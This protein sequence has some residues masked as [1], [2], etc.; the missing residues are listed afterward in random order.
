MVYVNAE[1]NLGSAEVILEPLKNTFY[2][3]NF[4]N[5]PYFCNFQAILTSALMN[6]AVK[7]V[8]I[9]FTDYEYG[10]KWMFEVP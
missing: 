10:P 5:F 1:A 4:T 6:L 2:S 8:E 3:T 9:M 7:R